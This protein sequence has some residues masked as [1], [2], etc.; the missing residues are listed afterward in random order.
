[1]SDNINEF[2]KD[3]FIREIA[4]RTG[5]TI[6]S[7]REVWGTIEEIFKDLIYYEKELLIPGLFKLSVT[8][9]SE[10]KGH[11]AV[12]DEPMI[13][14]KSKRIVFKASPTLKKLFKDREPPVE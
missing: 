1:M 14:R 8:T 6:G 4:K 13:V 11:N 9:I 10:H 3:D 5:Y 2:T 12:K 7:M